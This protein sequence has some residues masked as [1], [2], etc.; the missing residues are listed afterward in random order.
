MR[1]R[2]QIVLDNRSAKYY[3]ESRNGENPKFIKKQLFERK[4]SRSTKE[5][6]VIDSIREYL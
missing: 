6:I 2:N 3:I 1:Q 4:L 5:E